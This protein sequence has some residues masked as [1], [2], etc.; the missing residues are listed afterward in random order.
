[1][2]IGAGKESGEWLVGVTKVRTGL[3]DSVV[4]CR[5]TITSGI[6]P[7]PSHKYVGSSL[8]D[9]SN[10]FVCVCD[11][12]IDVVSLSKFVGRA[13]HLNQSISKNQENKRYGLLTWDTS[14]IQHTQGASAPDNLLCMD[15]TRR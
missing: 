1:M 13:V 9:R 8:K 3:A 11:R 7:Y 6:I 12:N 5:R 10:A 4:M 2:D 14:L 15:P